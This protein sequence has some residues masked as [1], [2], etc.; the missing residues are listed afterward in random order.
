MSRVSKEAASWVKE[1]NAAGSSIVAA[2]CFCF[3]SS[4]AA[5]VEIGGVGTIAAKRLARGVMVSM[6]PVPQQIERQR[7]RE[8]QDSRSTSTGLTISIG[9]YVCN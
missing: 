6:L 3:S 2:C 1:L 5:S 8:H 4:S 7:V 9:I